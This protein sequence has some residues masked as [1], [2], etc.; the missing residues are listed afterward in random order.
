MKTLL[1]FRHGKSDWDAAFDH[2]HDR[3][4]ARRGREAARSMGQYLSEQGP[5]PDR[6]LCSSAVRARDTLERASKAGGWPPYS[7]DLSRAY[8]DAGPADLVAALK[9]QDDA[10]TVVMVV[11]HEP[12][13]STLI[14]DL[15]GGFPPRFPTAALAC[16][17][18]YVDRWDATAP[19]RG[20][21]R[22]LVR[23][24]ELEEG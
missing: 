1:I 16:L 9:R 6:V 19:G 7:L 14:S 24:R 4:L 2:D 8:Y 12:V 10:H 13:L 18:F 3:P 17:T 11:G 21:L 15:T 5:L 23:P 22:W 20:R